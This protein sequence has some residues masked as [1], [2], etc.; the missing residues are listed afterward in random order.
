MMGYNEKQGVE[1]IERVALEVSFPDS[2]NKVKFKKNSSR[3]N[4]YFTFTFVYIISI[5]NLTI[6]NI[7]KGILCFL[8][9]I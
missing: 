2:V 7:S 9:K 4:N 3:N 5:D 1:A 6:A 8:S